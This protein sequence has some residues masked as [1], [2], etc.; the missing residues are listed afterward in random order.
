MLNALRCAKLLKHF[1]L[2]LF[3]LNQEGFHKISINYAASMLLII[4]TS[5][6]IVRRLHGTLNGPKF[7]SPSLHGITVQKQVHRLLQE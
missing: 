2:L 7:L 5:E 1:Q 4:F 3:R 6:E